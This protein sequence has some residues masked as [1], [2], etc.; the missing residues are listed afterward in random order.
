MDSWDPAVVDPLAKHRP[1]HPVQQRWHGLSGRRGPPKSI[2][3]M[4]GHVETFLDRLEIE[5]G[6]SA[7]LLDRVATLRRQVALDRPRPCA[8]PDPGWHRA[9]RWRRDGPFLARSE[10][11][12]FESGRRRRKACPFCSLLRPSAARRPRGQ[13]LSRLAARTAEREPQVTPQA[14][15]GT[16][17]RL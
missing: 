1:G 11:R 2:E 3:A 10:G 15:S 13:F 5:D 6:R 14:G 9:A 17:R 7:W 12:G 16:N 4:A 8:P